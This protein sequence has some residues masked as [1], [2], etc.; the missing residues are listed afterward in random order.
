MATSQSN[1]HAWRFRIIQI[2]KEKSLLETI[3]DAE[4]RITAS[5]DDQGFN[6]ITVNIKDSQIPYI[7]DATT[8]Q[9]AWKTLKE[10]HQGIGKNGKMVLMQ[11][12]WEL[13]MRE[14]DDMAEYLNQLREFANQLRKLCIDGKEMEDSE[15][16]MILTLSLPDS[17]E[18]LFIAL[19]DR[20][21]VV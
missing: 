21:S 11:R 19:Q 9:E 18:P 14:T 1:Y 20:K 2:L 15:L 16:T 10:V 7:Q 4:D 3:T 6:I 5:K 17:Y 8:T 13:K 12:L